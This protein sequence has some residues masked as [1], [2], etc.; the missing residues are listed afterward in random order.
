MPRPG[1]L[2]PAGLGAGAGAGERPGLIPSGPRD[3]LRPAGGVEAWSAP[4]PCHRIK[5]PSKP[6]R[7]K[8]GPGAGKKGCDPDPRPVP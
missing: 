1:G 2:G 4:R 6:P 7:A 3:T 5:P 8:G